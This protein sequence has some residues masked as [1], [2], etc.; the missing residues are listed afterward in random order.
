M[1][2]AEKQFRLKIVKPEG[3][4]FSGE[5]VSVTLPT[6]HGQI[7]ILKDHEA[8]VSSLASGELVARTADGNVSPMLISGGFLELADNELI[9]LADSAEHVSEIDLEQAQKAKAEL[10]AIIVKQ[11]YRGPEYEAL[12]EKLSKERSRVEISHKW[13]KQ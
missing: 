4:V 5:V 6:V 7:T 8:Y 10:E 12:L 1:Q 13:R 11:E 3:D 9:V 2:V